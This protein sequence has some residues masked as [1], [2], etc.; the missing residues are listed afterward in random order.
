MDSGGYI[1]IYIRL[2]MSLERIGCSG[3]LDQKEKEVKMI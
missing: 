3:R 2:A 1:N